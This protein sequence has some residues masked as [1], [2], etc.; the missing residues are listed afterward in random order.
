MTL[1]TAIGRQSVV[2]LAALL[3][4]LRLQ[5]A[6]PAQLSRGADRAEVTTTVPSPSPLRA[7]GNRLVDAAGRTVRLRGVMLPDPSKV[8]SAGHW[9]RERFQ[10]LRDLGANVVRIPVHPQHWKSDPDYLAKYLDPAV[11]WTGE[12]GLYVILDWHSIGNVQTGYT[13]SVPELFCH[14][15]AMTSDFWTRVASRYRET[16]HLICEVFNEPHNITAAEWREAAT[17]LIATIRQQGARQLVL[18][19]GLDYGRELGWVMG[20]P[21]SDP[22]VAYVSHIFPSHDHRGWDQ[23]FGNVAARWPVVITEWGFMDENREKAGPRAYLAGD[24][25]GYGRTLMTY[26]D[27]HGIGWVACWYDDEWQPAMLA[28][29]GTRYTRNG[30]FIATELRRGRGRGGP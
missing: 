3:L 14:T 20:Q 16:P 10:A 15:E 19:G 6:D 2:A 21:V 1:V 17:R 9:T 5:A 8:A 18:V 22:N 4:A 26:L 24:A 30:E 13:P 27:Q 7:Q 28:K 11:R 29:G 12:L 23:W 25:A